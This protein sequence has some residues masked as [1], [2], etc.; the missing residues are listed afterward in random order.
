[1]NTLLNNPQFL[2]ELIAI[3]EKLNQPYEEIHKTATECLKE[4]QTQHSPLTNIL[5]LEFA[6]YILYKGYNKNIDVKSNQIKAIAKMARQHPI[7]FVMTHKTY[8]DMFVL[9]IVLMQHGVPLPHI[10]A[11]INLDIP[12][13]SQLARQ[14]GVIFIRRSFKDDLIYKVC[15]RHFI[16]SLLNTGA[17]FMW[18]LEGTRSRTG[19]LVWPKMGILKYIYEA[20]QNSKRKVKYVP[21]SIVYD[22]IPDVQDMTAEGR[23]N[24]KKK[25]SLGWF[26]NYARR[27]NHNLGK[28]SLRFGQPVQIDAP[29]TVSIIKEGRNTSFFEN[30]ISQFAIELAHQ[31]NNITPVT[32]ASLICIALLAKF[33]LNKRAIENNVI[34][35]MLLI[36]QHEPDAMVDRGKAMGECIQAAI[37]LLLRDG[38]LLQR[39]QG[40]QAKFVLNSENYLQATYYANMSIQ[41]LFKRAF[42]E[43]ALLQKDAVDGEQGTNFW[44]QILALR[45][46]FKFEFFFSKKLDFINEI[47]ENLKAL[48]VNWPHL[49]NSELTEKK[50]FLSLQKTLIAPVVLQNYVEAYRVVAYALKDRDASI[51]FNEKEFI[52]D[53]VF[54]SEELHWQGIIQRVEAVRKPFLINGIRLVQNLDLI[55]TVTN[56]KKETLNEF[57]LQLNQLAEKIRWLQGTSLQQVEETKSL[58]PVEREIVPGSKTSAIA[59]SILES[60]KGPHIGAFFDLDRTLISSFSAKRFV[61]TRM[62]S[63]KAS[64][65]EIIAQF[66]GVMVYA[67]GQRNFAGLASVS[68]QGVK[69]IS[70]KLFIQLGEEVYHKHLSKQIYPE[71]RALVNAHLAQGHTVAI[72]SAATPYQVNPIAHDLNIEH[73]MCTQMEVKNDKFTG[74]IVEP[75]CWGE[76][77]AWAGQQLAE[78]HQLDLSKSYFYTDSHEDAPLL[79]IVGKPQPVNPDVQL[80]A[81]AFKNGWPVYR[82]DSA[83]RPGTNAMLRT[84]LAASSLFPAALSGLANG[85]VKYSKVD[86]TNALM[87][88]VGDLV[89]GAAGIELVVKG[90]ENLWSHRPAVFIF[91]HQ[92]NT[93]LF[94]VS[95]LIRKNATG[96]AKKELKMMPVI[97]QLMQAAGVIFIDRKDKEKAIEAMAPAVEALKNGISL[98]IFPEGTRSKNYTLGAFKKGAFHMAMQAGVPIVPVIIRNAHDAMPRGSNIFR[99]A[100]IEV[101]ALKPIATKRWK[102]ERL[103]FHIKKIR[104]MYLKELGQEE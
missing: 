46:L 53:C 34:N 84:T 100:A 20:E 4:L 86:G 79:E 8:L 11:G 45:K 25:E 43:L 30:E 55:P 70:E 91:N 83:E 104:K 90:K 37:N 22:L 78:K 2:K 96:I 67:M 3:S 26:L 19:K 40:I 15:L 74:N 76:G 65:K 24:N 73:V 12:G 66:G 42:I 64:A 51:A 32:T 50:D 41:H 23:G 94:I 49:I 103:D 44:Q 75:A 82:F 60:E 10:F 56:D 80:S 17:H 39:G 36:E 52:N 97:G 89:T 54:I 9:G 35:L 48:S 68:A 69:G 18:A 33:S 71:A 13:I 59:Q 29:K 81:M 93:D 58:I 92:S 61:Q 14:N 98:I 102:K 95:K 99:P 57:L 1:V 101:I 87:A 5:G 85:I 31:V 77:K 62:F 6:Q 16:G 72:I 88:T 21:V 63:G 7:A 38:L 47:E 28:I 27:L